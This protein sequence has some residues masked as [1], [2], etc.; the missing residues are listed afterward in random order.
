MAHNRCLSGDLLTKLLPLL[1]GL[2]A[3]C[4]PTLCHPKPLLRPDRLPTAATLLQP[5]SMRCTEAAVP[6]ATGA[7]PSGTPA[8]SGQCVPAQKV[9]SLGGHLSVVHGDNSPEGRIYCPLSCSLS[10][11]LTSHILPKFLF[12]HIRHQY[13]SLCPIHN[14]SS[15]QYI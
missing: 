1:K 2:S 4:S 8:C 13:P 10:F 11:I 15:S 9:Q 14:R 12:I 3:A 6:V 7:G 5:T